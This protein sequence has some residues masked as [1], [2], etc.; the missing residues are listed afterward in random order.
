[1]KV[2]DMEEQGK[3]IEL[4]PMEKVAEE[5]VVVSLE[6]DGQNKAVAKTLSDEER[7][8]IAEVKKD[9]AKN[10]RNQEL[11]DKEHYYFEKCPIWYVKTKD[12]EGNEIAGHKLKDSQ[13]TPDREKPFEMFNCMNKLTATQ[14]RYLSADIADKASGAMPKNRDACHNINIANQVLA[15]SEPGDSVEAKLCLQA[16]VLYARGMEFLQRSDDE[17]RIPQSEFY[18]RNAVKLLRLHNET[19][20]ALSRYRRKGEQRVIVQHIN[21][22]GGGQAVVGG[23]FI[24]GGGGK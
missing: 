17:T 7:A 13:K 20:E 15:D 1:M 18:V 14:D 9:L 11:I 16:H 21:V 22:E 2:F 6:K 10:L 24:A 4:F 23:A 19:I 12:D 8:A 5:S 3:R